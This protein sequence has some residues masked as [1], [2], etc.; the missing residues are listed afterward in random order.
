MTQEETDQM[1]ANK[2]KLLPDNVH[3]VT[4]PVFLA[5]MHSRYH[6]LSAV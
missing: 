1:M 5:I 6:R 3:V 2:K 4:L